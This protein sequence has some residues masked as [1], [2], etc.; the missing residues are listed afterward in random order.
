[1]S[2]QPSIGDECVYRFKDDSPSE[3]VRIVELGPPKQHRRIVIEHLDGERAGET[4]DVPVRRLKV[5]WSEVERYDRQQ[6]VFARFDAIEYEIGEESAV[7]AVFRVLI[8]SSVAGFGS[9]SVYFSTTIRSPDELTAITGVDTA[10][11]LDRFE[12]VEFDGGLVVSGL[13]TLYIC[14]LAC[15]TSPMPV[16]DDLRERETTAMIRSKNGHKDRR[17]GLRGGESFTPYEDHEHYLTFQRPEF[18]LLRQWCGNRAVS[19]QERMIAAEQECHR[20][21]LVLVKALERIH[22]TEGESW[23][24]KR[25]RD[26]Y[27]MGR[28]TPASVRPIVERPLRYDDCPPPPG[29]NRR[30]GRKWW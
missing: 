21:E 16:L 15:R 28:I 12:S 14:E 18:E 2:E 6:E 13:A 24:L 19:F 10:E 8:P 26:D 22:H 4:E 27:S 5:P 3:R 25:L 17:Q 7:Q 11:I 20:L 1:M 29:S 23:E 9:A 30:F